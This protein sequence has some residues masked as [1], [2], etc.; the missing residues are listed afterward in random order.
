MKTFKKNRFRSNGFHMYRLKNADT[1]SALS[2]RKEGSFY[3]VGF[4]LLSLFKAGFNVVL[5]LVYSVAMFFSL[6]MLEDFLLYAFNQKTLLVQNIE[7]KN[8]VLIPSDI[9]L[10][11]VKTSS[12]QSLITC[13]IRKIREDI[14][15]ISNIKT[16]NIQKIFP[17]KLI[18]EI[19][20]REPV[21]RMIM[22]GELIDMEGKLVKVKNGFKVYKHLPTLQG[23]NLNENGEISESDIL[24][25]KKIFRM[26]SFINGKND[27]I[28]TKMIDVKK[29]W[30]DFYFEKGPCVRIPFDYENKIFE[31][32]FFVI[33]DLNEKNV[34]TD[35]IDMRFDNIVV[36]I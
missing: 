29:D 25:Y 15:A 35:F 17:G 3:A 32:L 4:F 20:E 23:I 21:F 2:A 8:N 18:I 27:S 31:R 22:G 9:I 5:T 12:T 30:A 28:K 10:D 19:D 14:E 36:K 13:D 1:N 11:T 7:I 6:V 34:N 24:I 33:Y 26:T 16:C